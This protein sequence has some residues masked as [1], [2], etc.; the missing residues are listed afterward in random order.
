MATPNE[1]YIQEN[2]R[3]SHKRWESMVVY[4]LHYA[5]RNVK[6]LSQYHVEKYKIDAYLPSINLAIEIDEEYHMNNLINDDIR[7]RFIEQ[8][9]G[10]TF[11]RINVT[12]DVYDQVDR[13]VKYVNELNLPAWSYETPQT[14]THTGEFSIAKKDKLEKTGTFIFMEKFKSKCFEMDLM[15]SKEIKTNDSG[16]G[17]LGIDIFFDGLTLKAITGVRKKIKFQVLEFDPNSVLRAGIN[18]S[19]LVQK[20]YSNIIG[21]EKACNED[22]ALELLISIRDKIG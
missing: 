10:C 9:L 12:E 11:I 22:K 2:T 18:I 20:K 7:Q 1:R 4:A 15:V 6:I 13:I 16:N 8:T 21:Y 3:T 5:L 19:D 17:M 14:N